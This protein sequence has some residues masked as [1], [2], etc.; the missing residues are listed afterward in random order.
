MW[1]WFLIGS[2]VGSS[3]AWAKPD[4]KSDTEI[5]AA[6][7][8]AFSERHP[9]ET[10]E[11]WRSL[12]PG[13]P[14]VIM[15]M[16]EAPNQPVRVRERLVEAL[17]AFEG[18]AQAEEFLRKQAESSNDD[19]VRLGA[20]QA[21]GQAGGAREAEFISEFL[22]HSDPQTRLVAAQALQKIDDPDAQARF[23]QYLKKEQAPWIVAKL[24]H[25]PPVPLPRL[26]P[27][28]SSEDRP[29]P[30]FNGKWA[31]LWVTWNGKGG[32]PHTEPASLTMQLTGT[33]DATTGSAELK[34][35]EGKR[36]RKW[37][38]RQLQ[39]S[40]HRVSGRVPGAL[41]V[42]VD[43]AGSAEAG[44]A[45]GPDLA[46]VAELQDYPNGDRAMVWRLT[47]LAGYAILRSTP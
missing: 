28:S 26:S 34:V 5:E 13:A 30:G 36:A 44:R 37:A 6:I 3:A 10:V 47:E 2:L 8:Q 12:G 42:A 9:K 43:V 33:G 40:G 23:A 4:P 7:H 19:V 1:V 27:V 11:W 35:G 39:L 45:K 25:Q 17:G 32:V 16:Y 14:A 22:S 41:L 46:F 31:G 24:T 38:L 21:V 29:A 15:R 18:N 20:I